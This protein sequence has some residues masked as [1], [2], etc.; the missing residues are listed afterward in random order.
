[1]LRRGGA[2]PDGVSAAGEKLAFGR[3]IRMSDSGVYECVVKNNMGV[4]KSDFTLT[5]TGN[6][7]MEQL[8]DWTAD[9]FHLCGISEEPNKNGFKVK[10]KIKRLG[11]VIVIL[12]P[13]CGDQGIREDVSSSS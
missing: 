10:L 8:C 1:M 9:C 5:V 7:G 4:G 2:L 3:P 12:L 13:P 6:I 11:L